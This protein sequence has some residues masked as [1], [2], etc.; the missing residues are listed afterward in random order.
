MEAANGDL[1][2]GLTAA[3]VAE[4]RARDGTNELPS[5][6]RRGLAGSLLAM[7]REPMSLLLL[8]CGGIYVALG[9]RQEASML[10]GFVVFI[11]VLS[12]AQE[13]KTERALESLRDMASPRALVIRDGQ[14]LR[15]SGR[16]L[17]QD[18]V[19]VVGEGDRVP[20]DA[21]VLEGS[22]LAADESVL[23]GESVPVRK[24]PWDG[25]EPVSRPGGDDL[26]FLYAGTLI[27]AGVGLARV[28]AT[29]PRSEIGRIGQAMQGHEAQETILQAETRHLVGKLAWI[30]GALCV[31]AAVGYGLAQR[32]ALAGVLAGLTLAMAILPNEFPVVVTM[33][34]ALGAWRLS[35][36]KVLVRRIP[37]VESLGAV[38]VLC[39][40]KTGTLTA[41]RM[42]VSR[43][44][45]GEETFD[46]G[47]LR[48]GPLP[49]SMHETVEYSILASRRDPFDPMERAFK[50]LGEEHLAG[51]EHLHD[52]WTLVRE[53]PLRRERLAVVQLWRAPDRP[54]LMVAAKGA[55]E[56]IADLCRSGADERGRIENGVRELA[57]GGLRV[58]AI[59]RGEVDEGAL[60][61]QPSAMDLRFVGLVGLVDPL[62][63][64]V[65]GAVAEC[66]RAGIRVVMITGDYPA[67][68]QAVARVAGLDA[69]RVVTGPELAAMTE[70][71]LRVRVRDTSVFARM[72]P[73]QKLGLVEA[74]T[75]EGEIVGMTGDGVNDAPALKAAHIGIAMGARGTDVAR[76]AAAVVLLEDDFA[77]LVHGV[78]TGRRIVDNLTKALAYILAVHLPIVGLTLVPIALGLPLVLLPIHI[79]FLHLVIDPACSIVFEGQT[80]EADVMARPPRDPRAPLFSR[81]LLAV[82]VLQGAS[83]L[84]VVLAV[85]LVGLR[86]GQ[87]EDDARAMTFATFLLSN[88]GLIFTNRS[89]SRVILSSSLR[90]GTLW[91]VTVGALLFL[92]LAVYAPPLAR[93]FRFAPLHPVDVG[94]CLAASAL[95]ITWFEVAKWMGQR[96]RALSRR[97]RPGRPAA[98]DPRPSPGTAAPGG[99]RCSARSD[100]RSALRRSCRTTG[101]RPRHPRFAGTRSRRSCRRNRRRTCSAP[102]CCRRSDTSSRRRRLPGSGS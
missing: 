53:Y 82:S 32:D 74:L 96:R 25:A 99:T 64:S 84:V 23:T 93:V 38:T 71:V 79:A 69:G 85:Y 47:H 37:A 57:G 91:A 33:F 100:R 45:A 4:R 66:R 40:D 73:E 7:L 97:T 94:L 22:H 26:P 101:I 102:R 36:R 17:V 72:L 81:R 70:D 48:S 52:D 20:A 21:V 9:D 58:L 18:D 41:N 61:A 76:E 44:R 92:V 6:E 35:R 15:V 80:E 78:R 88:L 2:V 95:G 50:E 43:I 87:S 49:E 63:E 1:R 60:P 30:A 46:I 77:S 62:R 89:W 55:P 83:V 59:A 42:T 27:T 28:H 34:L 56:A 11:M 19:I 54:L 14:R 3:E 86:I 29:G 24:R 12:L 31:L 8:V 68:A 98:A 51:T 13:R 5:P 65:P 90:D 10:L 75:S 67:T 16:E 39:V